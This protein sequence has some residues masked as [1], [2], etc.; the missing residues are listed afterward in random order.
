MEEKVLGEFGA[1]TLG[2]YFWKVILGVMC[3]M[4]IEGMKVES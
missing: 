2:V 4:V 3:W 1:M